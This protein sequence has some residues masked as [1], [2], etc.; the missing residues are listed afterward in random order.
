MKENKTIAEMTQGIILA[1][2]EK[3]ERE[4]S[5]YSYQSEAQLEEKLIENLI[6]QGYERLLAHSTEEL[7]KN[8]KSQ[9]ERLNSVVFSQADRKDLDYQTMREYQ[10]FQADCVNGSKDTKELH[11][12]LITQ[13]VITRL[14]GKDGNWR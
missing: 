2:F 8:L 3:N 14:G 6:A 9:M 11:L 10:N 12:K 5:D 4:V 13:I 7:Y 1:S